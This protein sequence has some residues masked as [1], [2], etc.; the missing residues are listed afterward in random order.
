[1]R[2]GL[3]VLALPTE[4]LTEEILREAEVNP[5]LMVESWPTSSAYEVALETAAAPEGLSQSLLRQLGMQRLDADVKEAAR[6]VKPDLTFTP[7]M[8]ESER[9][10]ALRGWHRAVE[11]AAK[12]AEPQA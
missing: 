1:M 10:L 9:A 3:R 6:V 7:A 4:T 5:C 12:W 11:R 8:G 2:M